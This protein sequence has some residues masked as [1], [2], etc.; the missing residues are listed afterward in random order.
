MRQPLPLSP[1]IPT[2]VAADAVAV[3]TRAGGSEKRPDD[4]PL[5]LPL[6]SSAVANPLESPCAHTYSNATHPGIKRDREPHQA[7]YAETAKTSFDERSCAI[8]QIIARRLRCVVGDGGWR[9]CLSS[10]G[11]LMVSTEERCRLHPYRLL[12]TSSSL[13][14]RRKMIGDDRRIQSPFCGRR[15]KLIY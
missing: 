2:P 11:C 13:P 5:P 14:T 12:G 7:V 10:A 4:P 9:C 1:S 3:G 15:S 8:V 6:L